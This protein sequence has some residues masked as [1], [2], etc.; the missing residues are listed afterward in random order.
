MAWVMPTTMAQCRCRG[1]CGTP[2][3]GGRCSIPDGEPIMRHVSGVRWGWATGE[4]KGRS[5]GY[6][7]S[8]IEAIGEDGLCSG[9]RGR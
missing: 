2:H 9:C 1:E 8:V 5:A 3:S 7:P 4:T 6:G